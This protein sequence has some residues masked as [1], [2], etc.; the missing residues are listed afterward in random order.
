MELDGVE[1]GLTPMA[2]VPVAAGRHT[3]RAH[4]PDGRVLER[5]VRVD[6]LNWRVIFR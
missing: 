6:E 1:I 4:L 3:F 2:D 5:E